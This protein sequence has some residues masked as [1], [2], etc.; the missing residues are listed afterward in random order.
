MYISKRHFIRQAIERLSEL[1]GIP[2]GGASVRYEVSY[3]GQRVDAVF[4]SGRHAFAIELKSTGSLGHIARAVDQMSHVACNLPNSLIPLLVV[5]FMGESARAYCERAKVAWLDLSGN[6]RIVAPDL[7]VY[8][9]GQRNKFR[10]PGRPESAFGP[11]G[12]RVARWLLM[13]PDELV[14]QRTL[15]SVTGLNEGYISRVV[16]KLIE[17]GLVDRDDQGIRIV[18]ASR[19]L[20]AWHDEY[21][22]DKHTLIRGHITPAGGGSAVDGVVGALTKKDI[23]HAITGLA[24]AWQWTRYARFRLST[25]YLGE[26]PSTELLMDLGFHKEPRGANTWLVVPNDEGV[27]HGARHVDGVY[28]AHPV[29][30][31]LDLK[32]HPERASEAADEVRKRLILKQR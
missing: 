26:V 18:D 8:I 23:R 11:R 4:E 31:Y 7:Y 21:R 15:A 20:N 14:R 22:F 5:P 13:N 32:A 10:R 17:M 6:A 29:Q 9:S 28:C 27:F 12:S 30:I 2:S 3:G 25:V 16:K 24:G 19:L 1:L